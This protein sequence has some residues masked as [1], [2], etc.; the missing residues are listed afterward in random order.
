MPF[1]IDDDTSNSN[2]NLISIYYKRKIYNYKIE[3]YYES[4]ETSEYERDEEK[5]ESLLAKYNDKITENDIPNKVKTGYE[6]DRNNTTT[7]PFTIDDDTSNPNINIIKVYYQRKT[8]NCR[9]EYYYE[10]IETSEYEI[11]NAKTE[12]GRAKFG[13]VI[14]SYEDKSKTGYELDEEKTTVMPFTIKDDTSNSEINVIK[15]YYNRKTY[16]YRIEYYYENI[17]TSEYEIDNAKTE[18]KTAKFGIII[19]IFEDKSKVGYELDEERT[20]VLPFTINDDTENAEINL[21]KVYYKRRAYTSRVEYYYESIETSE[22][23]IDN[24]KTEERAV[25]YGTVISSYEDKNKTGYELDEEKTTVMPFTITEEDNIIKVYYKRGTFGY[26]VEYYYDDIKKEDATEQFTTLYNEEIQLKDVPNK[27]IRGYRVDEN[28]TGPIPLVVSEKPENNIMKIYYIIDDRN[29][30]ELSYTVEYYK[31]GKLV[32]EDTQIIIKTVQILQ[33]DTLEV[34]KTNIN[35]LDKYVGYKFDKVEPEEIPDIIDD[36]EVIKVYYVRDTFAYT[37]EYYYDDILAEEKTEYLTALYGDVLTLDDIPDNNIRGYKVDV[38]KTGPLPLVISERPENNIMKVYYIIDDENVKELNYT[39][40]YYKDGELVEEDIEFIT[41]KV[42]ILQPDIIEVDIDSIN[43]LDKYLGY[44]FDK[45]VP[46]T[47]PEEVN[48]G[49]TI[50][51]YY[52]LDVEQIK[53]LYYTVE[54]YKD[55]ELV[56]ED[57]MKYTKEVQVLQSNKIEVNKEEINITNKYKGY[58][59]NSISPEEIPEEVETGTTIKVYY[60]TKMKK[61]SYKIEYYKEGKIVNEDTEI[62]TITVPELVESNEIEVDKE[63]IDLNKYY[64]YKVQKTSPTKIPNIVEDGD[65]IKIYYI[66]DENMTKTLTYTIEY[67]IGSTL[68]KRDTYMYEE[69]VQV[70]QPDI[71]QVDS[72]ILM[73]EYKYYG[74]KLDKTEP[75]DISEGIKTGTEI[76]VYYEVDPEQTKT[77]GYTVEYYKDGELVKNDTQ[78]YTKTVQVLEGD[79]LKVD[80]NKI[81]LINKYEGY[82]FEK[83][84][85]SQIQDYADDGDIIKVYYIKD[86]L[87]KSLMKTGEETP[88]GLFVGMLVGFAIALISFIKYRKIK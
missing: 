33:P 57:T 62:V 77:I 19:S 72:E 39:V 24:T 11:D 13:T 8:Y 66:I 51:V 41:K 7:L 35:M 67:Y 82:L 53:E 23:E 37:I 25:K 22:Y 52:V 40:E 30:K 54:Y 10:S 74:Y 85:P 87:A 48:T 84:S 79:S 68:A 76:K 55:G 61:L 43:T 5:E 9:L 50:Q 38:A 70:L 27:N 4:I 29:V 1:T 49:A 69:E 16:G 2:I 34:D 59:F 86:Q 6:L 42:Q 88:M 64:G 36:G 47:I 18:N 78:K 15:V 3:Y 75:A 26:T 32:E 21:I 58:E 63:K 46:E 14:S 28:K 73:P 17:Q 31:E 81:N 12:Y 44:K 56:E 60:T 65:I 71:I 80:R 45:T 83:T 20:T